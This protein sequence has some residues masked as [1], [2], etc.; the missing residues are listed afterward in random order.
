MLT[1]SIRNPLTYASYLIPAPT[2]T[3]TARQ[4]SGGSHQFLQIASQITSQCRGYRGRGCGFTAVELKD[5]FSLGALGGS[6]GSLGVSRVYRK[7]EE[8]EPRAETGAACENRD[9]ESMETSRRSSVC[10]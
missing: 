5:P 9:R 2:P 4:G 3:P 7:D 1:G 8:E 10:S 6:D